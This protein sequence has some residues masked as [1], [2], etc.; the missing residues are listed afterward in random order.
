MESWR[1]YGVSVHPDDLVSHEDKPT[2][3]PAA[4][5]AA[6][7]KKLRCQDLPPIKVVRRSLDARKKLDHPRFVYVV[8]VEIRASQAQKLGWKTKPGTLERLDSAITQR[9]DNEESTKLQ[10]LQAQQ[11]LGIQA[12]SIAN[13]NSQNILSLFR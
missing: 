5:Q 10:A 1:L 7:R 8:D 6:M 13:A 2:D 3:L 11:Q 12:L 9:G 4:L